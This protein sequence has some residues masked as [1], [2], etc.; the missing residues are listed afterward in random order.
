GLKTGAWAL[1]KKTGPGV[2][3]GGAAGG[4]PARLWEADLAGPLA[5]VVGSEGRG[6][7]RLVRET[8]DS[9]VSVPMYGRISSLNAAVAAAL[10]LFE[11]RRRREGAP[12][13]PAPPRGQGG[14]GAAPSGSGSPPGGPRTSAGGPPGTGRGAG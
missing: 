6:L 13:R 5:V 11:A 9:L 3:G 8:C 1:H 10:V 12:G 7:G 2:G 14:S 4:A